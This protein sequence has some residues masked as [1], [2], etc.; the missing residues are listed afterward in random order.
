MKALLKDL[1]PPVLWRS[2]QQLRHRPALPEWEYAGKT[3]AEARCKQARGWNQLTVKE[4]S[5]Q[6]LQGDKDQL[7]AGTSFPLSTTCHGNL[8]KQNRLLV[9][10]Y[11]L[12]LAAH[13]KTHLSILDWGGN[14]GPYNLYAQAFLPGVT[15]DYHCKDVPLLAE[16]G[17]KLQP[18][19]C[20]YSS[21]SCL[22]RQYDFVLV[23]GSLQY[24]ED[25]ASTLELLLK[26]STGYLLL[27]Q[28]FVTA[29]HPCLCLHRDPGGEY[30]GWVL[31]REDVVESATGARLLHEFALTTAPTVLA[32]SKISFTQRAFLWS[33]D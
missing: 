14:L 9:F 18:D 1:T 13:G 17:Q 21:N 24:S 5:E 32:G 20:F 26:A 7:S 10:A 22:E 3:W 4:L 28:L 29:D 8:F 27:T 6:Y 25:W 16:A 2:F 23:S 15:I 30:V 19:V 33:C 31:Q 12:A 11:S